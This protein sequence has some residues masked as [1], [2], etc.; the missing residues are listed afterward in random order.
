VS[1]QRRRSALTVVRGCVVSFWWL[2]SLTPILV[3]EST[4][5]FVWDDAHVNLIGH[6]RSEVPATDDGLRCEM[7]YRHDTHTQTVMSLDVRP[8][9]QWLRW[10]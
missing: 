6:A 10:R 3:M 5:Y 9:L 1:E 2:P 8:S 7:L 4:S